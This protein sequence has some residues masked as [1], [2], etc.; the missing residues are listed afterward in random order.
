MKKHQIRKAA[1]YLVLTGL[2]LLIP[3][4][5]PP[6]V[7]T[8]TGEWGYDVDAF[9]KLETSLNSIKEQKLENIN[10]G[11]LLTDPKGIDLVPELNEKTD[12]SKSKKATVQQVIDSLK[13]L[14]KMHATITP[15][16]ISITTEF[17]GKSETKGGKIKIGKTEP[18]IVYFDVTDGE[19]KDSKVTIR[20]KDNDHIE[21]WVAPNLQA[22]PYFRIKSK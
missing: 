7:K 16:S 5:T 17:E 6:E 20:I 13:E 4:C 8:M 2:I 1:L 3:S 11:Q 15:E 22:F 14:A 10:F 19:L 21:I 9:L 12:E 18:G